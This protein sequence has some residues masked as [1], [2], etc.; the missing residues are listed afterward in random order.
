MIKKYIALTF[1]IS[2]CITLSAQAMHGDSGTETRK[3]EATPGVDRAELSSSAKKLLAVLEEADANGFT[4]MHYAAWHENEEVIKILLAQGVS[5][6]VKNEAGFTPLNLM[7]G[8]PGLGVSKFSLLFKYGADI[9]E[10]NVNG[11]RPLNRAIL[12]SDEHVVAW[13]IEH[14]AS[15]NMRTKSNGSPLHFAAHNK[16][17]EIFKMILSAYKVA[18]EIK[19]AGFDVET[20]K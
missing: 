18:Q 10:P 6:N 16:N 8:Y 3:T 14:G 2:C 11:V 4:P 7:C 1:V 20:L 9:E 13:L 17:P 15:L 5:I 19:D 12:A